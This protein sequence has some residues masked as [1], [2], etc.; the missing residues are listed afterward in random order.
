MQIND[1]YFKFTFSAN[2]ELAE[3]FIAELSE[4]GFD[5]FEEL[6]EKL[7]AYCPS[8]LFSPT[9]F[10]AFL[11]KYNLSTNSFQKEEV[12]WQ[13]WNQLW[14][15]NYDPVVLL[16]KIYVHAHFHPIKDYPYRIQVTPKMSFGT[17][18]HST[19]SLMMEMMLDYDF[20]DKT[21]LDAGTG[22]GILAIFAEMLGANRVF[23]Y[24]IDEWP[25]ENTKENILLNQCGSIEVKQ[26]V[27]GDFDFENEFEVVL[28]NINRN[29]LAEEISAYAKAMKAEALLFLSGF[30]VEDVDYLLAISKNHYLSLLKYNSKNNW[31]VLVLQKHSH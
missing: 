6:D 24:D 1:T 18:H 14:E 31:A 15:S 2:Q 3:I 30:Y 11:E 13:N 27:I 22:T 16:D 4:L 7:L 28:A 23:A 17:G 9:D 29:I 26:G 10:E 20:K 8:N 25:V 19:T 12:G 21:V 5:S